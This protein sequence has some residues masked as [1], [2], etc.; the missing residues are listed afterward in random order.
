MDLGEL[1]SR[2]RGELVGPGED[3]WDAARQAWNLAAQRQPAAVVYPTEVEDAA[4]AIDYAR[5][6]GLRVAVEGTGHGAVPLGPLEDALLVRTDR[7]VEV[8]VDVERRVARVGAGVIWRDVL[9]ATGES[10]LA[11]LAG[12]SPDVGVVGYSLGGGLGWLGRRYGLCCNS[13]TA[14]EL[15]TADGEARRV[16]QDHEPELFWALRG[17]GCGLGIVTAMEIGLVP[18]GEVYAGSLVLPAGDDARSILQAY[19]EWAESV[20]DE[21]TS[22]ARFL[23]LPPLPEVPEE[24]RDRPLITLGACYA[25]PPEEGAALV[26]PLRE[27][28]E[29]VMD[30]FTTMPASQIV[31]IHMDPEEPVPGLIHHKLL[32]ELPE[33]AVDAFVDVAGPGSGSPLLVAELRQ[34]GG[35]L[36][37]EPENAGALSHLDGAFVCLGVG[38]AMAPEQVEP[39]NRHLDALT[40]ALSP[41]GAERDYYNFAERAA[42][43]SALFGP[44]A[45]K[46]LS[47]V[48]STWD[49]EGLFRA[50]H[51][52]PI[53]V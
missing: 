45:L 20:P 18:V 42:E 37:T 3:R 24:L 11:A 53:A 49:P 23:H 38:I 7:L 33:E 44:E 26:A 40:D 13:V 29:P 14:V 34:L 52:V 15:V 50:T 48:K 31:T 35:A 25:G 46:R 19:R 17:G 8:A 16:D 6:N 22:I 4:A 28:G 32:R 27:L 30:L 5:Q 51:Q 12:S 41:W 43:P 1:K 9:D 10:G 21:L 2:L 47:R 39:V 36:A